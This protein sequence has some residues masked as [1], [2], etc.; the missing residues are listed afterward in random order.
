MED[1]D[2]ENFVR[3]IKLLEDFCF[4]PTRKDEQTQ[5]DITV[6][7]ICELCFNILRKEREIPLNKRTLKKL[8][9]I[10]KQLHQLANNNI[11]IKKKRHILKHVLAFTNFIKILKKSIIPALK[12]QYMRMDE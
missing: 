6:H 10:R 4:N 9:P 11:G 7:G 2:A 8:Y 12:K 1:M 5:T 3:R